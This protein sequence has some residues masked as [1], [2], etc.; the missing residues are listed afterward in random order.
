M[1]KLNEELKRGL[2]HYIETGWQ[3]DSKYK[4]TED[5]KGKRRTMAYSNYSH[6]VINNITGLDD[7]TI[8]KTFE[9]KMLKSIDN[10]KNKLKVSPRS[11]NWEKTRNELRIWA[12]SNY[13]QVMDLYDTD[14]LGYGGREYDVAEAVLL[15]AKLV[16]EDLFKEL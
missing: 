8:D 6:G 3:Y 15:I 1:D 13:K 4:L 5:I 11:E 2:F 10:E 12:L 14:F 16:S 9:I 7:D